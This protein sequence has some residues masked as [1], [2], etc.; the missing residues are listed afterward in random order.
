MNT[1]RGV[2]VALGAG[3]FAAPQTLFAQQ[4]PKVWRVGFLN[5]LTIPLLAQGKASY[6]IFVD[7]L[8]ELGYVERKNLLM[9]L[10]VADGKPERLPELAAELVRL[11]VD[12]IFCNSG[13]ALAAKRATTTVP[14]VFANTFDPVAFGL[15]ASLSRPGANIT[16][17]SNGLEDTGG[18]NMEY[19]L[20]VVPKLARVALLWAAGTQG[21][22]GSAGSSP[23]PSYIAHTQAAARK[24]GVEVTAYEASTPTLVEAAFG[25]MA[26]DRC[27]A[28]LV[29][30]GPFLT[31]QASQITGL[32]AKY[33]LPALF[34]HAAYMAAGGL[35]SY[36]P[37]LEE[38][39]RQAA[40]QVDKI[41]KGAKPADIP[42]EQPNEF[43][44]IVNTK[45]AKA[46][47]RSFP[48]SLLV[49]ATN[50]A[51]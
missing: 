17:I 23:V 42:V 48:Q 41:L 36:G 7:T 27:G 1:R 46:L 9:E 19:L 18:K 29:M 11:N 37:K 4:L 28:L 5:L 34:T 6:A 21:S 49:R 2:V 13:T 14:I 40:R 8:A 51:E 26:R 50:V 20:A 43:E 22:T 45:V 32:A 31:G 30:P 38:I 25:T 16:G 15:V 24:A 44:L 47:G 10:R 35:M 3:A 39:Y 33:Q 12:V